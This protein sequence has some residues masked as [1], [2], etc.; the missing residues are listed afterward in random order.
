MYVTEEI[1]R[2]VAEFRT[3]VQCPDSNAN[4]CGGVVLIGIKEEK[5]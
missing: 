4:T 3:V 1:A 5:G 2:D